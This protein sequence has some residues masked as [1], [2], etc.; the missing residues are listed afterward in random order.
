MLA[1]P[2]IGSWYLNNDSGEMFEV[3]A[4]DQDNAD[5]EVQYVDGAVSE[6][7][8]DSWHLLQLDEIPEP[9]DWSAPY[10]IEANEVDESDPT[11]IQDEEDVWG[12]IH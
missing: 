12:L 5:I 10:E 11:I 2:E 8:M 9:E 1:Y 7:D 6:Y 4:L 3:V